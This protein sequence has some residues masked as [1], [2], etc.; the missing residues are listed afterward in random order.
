MKSEFKMLRGIDVPRAVQGK[1]F[2]TCQNYARE[3]ERVQAK[4]RRLCKEAGGDYA[5]ELFLFLTTD[6]S[7]Q[8]ITT[9]Y[10]ISEATLCRIRRRFYELW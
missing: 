5:D 9:D 1:I 7:W 4:I 8:R 10:F 6:I 3:P 2:Y